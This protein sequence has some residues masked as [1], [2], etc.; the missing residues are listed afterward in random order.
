MH[1]ISGISASTASRM[2]AAAAGG[3]T[4]RTDA[5]APVSFI[6]SSTFLKTGRPRCISPA[7]FGLTPPTIVVPYSIA[8]SQWNVAVFP[9]KPCP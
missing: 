9:V 8:C 2:A 4:Y 3:G 1:T 5:F 7:F 6:A